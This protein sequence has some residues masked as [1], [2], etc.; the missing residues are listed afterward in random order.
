VSIRLLASIVLFLCASDACAQS[1]NVG[2]HLYA[3]KG[4]LSHERAS[5]FGEPGDW[6]AV[7][8]E[9]VVGDRRRVEVAAG[10]RKYAG[11]E[12][13]S[14]DSSVTVF[15]VLVTEVGEDY[16]R[17]RWHHDDYF[18]TR[19]SE[20]TDVPLREADVLRM[21]SDGFLVR[22]DEFGA[23]ERLENARFFEGLMAELI[24]QLALEQT[25]EESAAARAIFDHLGGGAF[26]VNK[27]LEPIQ[28]F[29]FVNGYE[30]EIGRT[31]PFE[32]AVPIGTER[33]VPASG[34]WK[35]VDLDVFEGTFGLR[36][37]LQVDRDALREALV[38]LFLAGGGP[39]ETVAQEM[40]AAAIEMNDVNHF[41]IDARTGWLMSMDR[42]RVITSGEVRTEQF[43]RIRASMMD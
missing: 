30:W 16:Y 14:E 36:Q 40:A 33:F 17:V 10:E 29:Y 24:E 34:H 25:D 11:T 37:F 8:A 41:V 42:Q 35:V 13:V 21:A 9:W 26:M 31:I 23:F 6:V 19:Q 12:V 3:A 22:T 15:R 43:V 32:D 20:E 7:I 38:D 28:F 39:S 27:L 18:D 1:G 4:E 5:K 2:D